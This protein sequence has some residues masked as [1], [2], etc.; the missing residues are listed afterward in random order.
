MKSTSSKNNGTANKTPQSALAEI[1]ARIAELQQQRVGLA[2]PL[3]NRYAE[4]LKEVTA[5][6]TQIRELDPAWRPQP[7]R[8]R[9]DTKIM[10]ILTASERPMTVDEIQAAVGNGFSKWKVKNT[11]KK[12]SIGPRA[13]FAVNDGRYSVKAAA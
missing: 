10:E 4:M 3:K 2:E 1:N 5:M 8:P 12:R 6:A 11:L 13:M 9:A 7:L